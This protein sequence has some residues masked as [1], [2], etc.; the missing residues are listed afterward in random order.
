[1]DNSEINLEEYNRKS[2]EYWEKF[3]GTISTDEIKY[4]DWLEK[5]QNEINN[6]KTPIIDL[7]CGLGNNTKYLIEKG[8]EVIP[9]DFS[10]I[11]I[12]NIKKNF[13][14][15][16]TTKVFDMTKGL[17]FDDNYTELIIADLSIHYFL[18][19][20][21]FY[22]LE[23]I[24]RVLK[25]NGILLLRVN[26]INDTNFG[27]GSGKEIEHHL[28]EVSIQN[29]SMKRFF[30]KEDIDRFFVGWKIIYLN[31][32]TL[33]RFLLEKKLWTGAVKVIK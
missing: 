28:Y 19:K 5:F 29:G 14:M 32:D 3:Y 11:A 33:R 10:A 18:E 7:G 27:A 1:M 23:E 20:T 22:V 25:P 13:P 2:I 26:S 24:K 6:C 31:E 21:T 4:D 16:K 8:K 9:C 15:I 30:D 12:Q 17:P